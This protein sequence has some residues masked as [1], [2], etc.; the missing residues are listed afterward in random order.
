MFYTLCV[1]RLVCSG[2]STR[3][4]PIILEDKF[5]LI[6]IKYGNNFI[7]IS[8]T[9]IYHPVSLN[10]LDIF[11]ASDGNIS[12]HSVSSSFITEQMHNVHYEFNM[13]ILFYLHF[14]LAFFYFIV[15]VKKVHMLMS[16][17]NATCS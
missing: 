4:R 10:R 14:H 9:F 17:L 15:F 16:P 8:L 6:M 7:C 3:D 1:Y 12:F 11:K 5:N 13:E 2:L